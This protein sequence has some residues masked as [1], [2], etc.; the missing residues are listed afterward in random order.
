MGFYGYWSITMQD[1][2]YEVMCYLLS[3]CLVCLKLLTEFTRFPYRK[4]ASHCIVCHE[5]FLLSKF[6]DFG[7][8]STGPIRFL[9]HWSKLIRVIDVTY[10]SMTHR[11]KGN[12]FNYTYINHFHKLFH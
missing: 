4:N 2:D 7:I 10:V 8:E 3:K 5:N 6:I 11:E 12:L 9:N 1:S